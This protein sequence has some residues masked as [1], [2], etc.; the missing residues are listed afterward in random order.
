MKKLPLL[1]LSI[2]PVLLLSGFYVCRLGFQMRDAH[3]AGM[4][5]ILIALALSVL[6]PTAFLLLR[7]SSKPRF[8]L[9]GIFVTSFVAGVVCWV[10]SYLDFGSHIHQFM[11][12]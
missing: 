4:L 1:F 11:A 3:P 9:G 6:T 8:R 12:A 7:L 10:G 5:L 2:L